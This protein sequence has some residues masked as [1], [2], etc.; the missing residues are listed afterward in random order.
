MSKTEFLIKP[1]N[2]NTN[3]ESIENKDTK[4]EKNKKEGILPCNKCDYVTKKQE[5]IDKHVKMKH[6]DHMCN[7][8][9]IKIPNF[10]GLLQHIAEE[11]VKNQLKMKIQNQGGE[12]NQENDKEEEE[13]K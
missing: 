5:T 11:H 8:C 4:K 9:H 3:S 1:K 10:M 12:N 6:E 7:E 13:K 2:K